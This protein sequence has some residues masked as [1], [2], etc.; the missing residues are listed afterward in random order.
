MPQTA[1]TPVR[2]VSTG[3]KPD[4]NTNVVVQG[5]TLTASYA[6]V[7]AADPNRS[8]GGMIYNTGTADAFVYFGPAASAADNAALVVKANGTSQA[9]GVLQL[10][11]VF[12]GVTY[13]GAIAAKGTA[14]Q[15]LGLVLRSH[16]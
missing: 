14:G 16:S 12:G 15:T 6:Q 11:N 2:I 13:T 5:V 9:Q 4:P 1:G 3:S 10:S 7:A 8:G